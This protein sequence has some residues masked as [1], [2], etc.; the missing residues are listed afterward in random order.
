[1]SSE[2]RKDAVV[3]TIEL[4]DLSA[5]STSGFSAFGVKFGMVLRQTMSSGIQEDTP[6]AGFS[7]SARDL[8]F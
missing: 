4:P 7:A 8:P 6:T 2:I 3:D 5:Q 1:M